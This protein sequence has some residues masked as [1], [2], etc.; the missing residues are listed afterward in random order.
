MKAASSFCPC[1]GSPS[2]RIDPYG[3]AWYQAHFF[4]CRLFLP[5]HKLLVCPVL[6]RKTPLRVCL[7]RENSPLKEP[8][9]LVVTFFLGYLFPV[10]AL[11]KVT[12]KGCPATAWVVLSL[13]H[14][15][16]ISQRTN[17]T[18]N[19]PQSAIHSRDQILYFSGGRRNLQT[20]INFLGLIEFIC[21]SAL[22]SGEAF[23]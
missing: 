2:G 19:A 7:G 11:R 20:I 18:F 8:N 16:K 10:K 6:N 21:S 1:G 9:S 14:R 4:V 3:F 5:P 23:F 22:A 15:R 12:V 17:S 13:L